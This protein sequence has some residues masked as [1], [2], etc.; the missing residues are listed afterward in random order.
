MDIAAI[1]AL[2]A[3]ALADGK[4]TSAEYDAIEAAIASDGVVTAEEAAL[5]EM[6]A[7]KVRSGEI[8][9]A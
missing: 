4:L 9:L 2:A 6:I 3:H 8:E 1:K 5:L 7:A